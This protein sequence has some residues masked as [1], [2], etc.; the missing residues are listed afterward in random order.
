MKIFI[1]A[2]F[3]ISLIFSSAISSGQ[4]SWPMVIRNSYFT[5]Y[6]ENLYVRSAAAASGTVITSLP[7]SPGL[8]GRLVANAVVSGLSV[9]SPANA[10]PTS[11]WYRV[12]LPGTTSA[13][14][15]YCAA[16]ATFTNPECNAPYITVGSSA[17]YIRTAPGTGNVTINS[18]GANAMVFPGQNFAVCSTATVVGITYYQISLPNNCY[19][20]SAITNTG[21]VSSGNTGTLVTQHYSQYNALAPITPP[22][23]ESLTTTTATLN[24]STS[25][26][27]SKASFIISSGSSTLATDADPNTSATTYT[28][29]HYTVSPVIA[30]TSYSVSIKANY[31]STS[32]VCV[33]DPSPVTTFTTSCT[34]TAPTANFT[35]SS[36]TAL[37]GSP[38]N[39][40][41]TTSGSPAITYSW[42]ASPPTGVTFSNSTAI[43]P[44]ITFA[45]TGG[46][47]IML[48][49]TNSCGSNAT[50]ASITVNPTSSTPIASFNVSAT[51]VNPGATVSTTNSTAAVPTATY[52]WSLSPNIGTS[53]SGSTTNP[54]FRFAKTGL[55]TIKLRATN[56]HGSDSTTRTITVTSATPT[57]NNATQDKYPSDNKLEPINIALGAYVYKHTDLNIAAIAKP[58]KFTR[59]YSSVNNTVNSSL[60]Y[61]WSHSYD[62]YIINQGDTLW[63]VHFA[64]GHNSYFIPD[65]ALT[66]ISYPYFS[67]TFEKLF[68]DPSNR[69]YTLTFRNKDVYNFDSAGKL[70]SIADLNGN[71]T[72]LTYTGANLTTIVAP[73]GRTLNLSYIE[74]HISA[75]TDPIGRTIRY[76]Y[77][78]DGNLTM[79]TN[80]MLAST[81][82]AYDALHRITQIVTP[83]GNSL[84]TNTYD[85]QGRV[86]SQSDAN[87]ST[88]TIA[89]NSPA[90]GDATITYPDGSSETDHH[91][92]SHRLTQQ[93]D[94]LG[95]QRSYSYDND[96][97]LVSATDE[98]GHT[99]TFT[100]DSLG[101]NI[102]IQQPYAAN[103]DI[104]Y[105]PT[106]NKPARITDA[107]GNVYNLYYDTHGNDTAMHLPNGASKNYTYYPNGQLYTA[108]DALGLITTYSYSNRG[109]LISVASPAG[110]K[111]FSYDS[112]GRRITQTDENSHTTNITYNNNDMTTRVTDALGNSTIDSFD[113]DNNRIYSVDRN[114]NHTQLNY[115]NKDRLTGITDAAGGHR[116]LAYDTRDNLVSVT[117]AINHSVSFSYNAKKQIISKTTSLGTTNYEYDGVGNLISETYASGSSRHYHYDSLNRRISTVDALGN[118]NTYTFN[119]LG[120]LTRSTDAMGRNT[121]YSYTPIGL[122][123]NI[124]DANGITTA[125]GY[126]L[127]G[128]RTSITDPN[129]HT[130]YFRYDAAG[131]VDSFIDGAG[132]I[133]SFLY[134]GAG[135]IL[136]QTKPGG[137]TITKSYNAVNKV[138]HVANSTGENYTYKYDA[139][140]NIDTIINTTGTSVFEYDNVNRLKKYTDMFGNVVQ[141]AY[142]IAGNKRSITYPGNH[143]VHYGYN[144]DNMLDSVIDWLGHIT[145]Y[146][147]DIDGKL[148]GMI[149]PNGAVCNY[150]YDNASR[151]ISETDSLPFN[152]IN[153][154]VFTLD[155]NGIR[156]QEQPTGPVPFHL[157]ASSFVNTYG[158]DDRLTGDQ[159]TAYTND[160]SGNRTSELNTTTTSY[161]F[162]ADNL[163]NT[164]TATSTGTTTYLYDALG[165]RV[166]KVQGGITRKY[167]LD[168][169]G[170]LS[171]VLMEQDN[172]GIVKAGYIYGL[173]LIARIDSTGTNIQYYH[174]DAKHNTVALSNQSG[175]VT[176]TYTYDPTGVM[177]KHTGTTQQP[178]TFLGEYGVQMETPTL[179]YVRARYYDAAKGRFLSKDPYPASLS[180]TQT[181]NRYVYGLNNAMS[182][183]DPTGFSSDDG[184]SWFHS[185]TSSVMSVG[186][187]KAGEFF[188]E[189]GNSLSHGTFNSVGSYLTMSS[190]IIDVLPDAISIVSSASQFAGDV[191]YGNPISTTTY[192]KEYS[193]VLISG[194]AII[195][196][197]AITITGAP[198][199]IIGAGIG[200]A[201]YGLD[202]LVDYELKKHGAQLDAWNFGASNKSD[203]FHGVGCN[204]N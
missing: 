52:T 142:D 87:G 149:Y 133:Y 45:T 201:A 109:D 200:L 178:C 13:V 19:N 177:L 26:Y 71:T 187:D 97:N 56:T 20:G 72:S 96:N 81:G 123:E 24:W 191:W 108:S 195:A 139:N 11:M 143:T 151:L 54:S 33:S 144:N 84:I 104:L 113:A 145:R 132:N 31:A 57:D 163:L 164:W 185:I 110:T 60:G 158:N 98:N 180:N 192:L 59:H 74:S 66:G 94:E 182:N 34:G 43:A 171:Q 168:L 107:L 35:P 2:I 166:Q 125:I 9:S 30:N 121:N 115:D 100:Y 42:T 147:Y 119:K 126:D 188:T 78:G 176:D 44:T 189:A 165:N 203:V 141:Y 129:Y 202:K 170:G 47:T 136:T 140:G 68:R 83:N 1:L 102:G 88:S 106:C 155:A 80:A 161:T 25:F 8:T 157:A 12:D 62:Y 174:F 186:F 46:Y 21:W 3:F 23:L 37:A 160:A 114:G 138:S 89:Y 179:Y 39:V 116:S 112:C 16:G 18:G 70:T 5:G 156:L 92:A 14:T 95:F 111:Y 79:V 67:G 93:T 190:K 154:S 175:L 29:S 49:A 90:S 135:N 63:N 199:I 38:I 117:D 6:P 127:N 27:P 131:R 105:N 173:G 118:T 76:D 183:I 162:S 48:T 150:A 128:R 148:S 124:T 36:S 40:T 64:D 15:G 41:N 122:P 193:T 134:D 50:T 130:Q 172:G 32:G 86:I 120:Q 82:T 91:D 22:L 184:N 17:V 4:S 53:S 58:L 65:P 99:T 103:T 198:A 152:L 159:T 153:K 28:P 101:N 204:D 197:T 194:A 7:T 146:N 137:A 73:G 85:A 181:L 51:T 61:G 196:T 77:D 169:S 55:Y 69:Q 75:I 10:Q 167:V